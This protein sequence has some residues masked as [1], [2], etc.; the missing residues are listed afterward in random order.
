MIRLMTIAAMTTLV[1][2]ACKNKDYESKQLEDQE[3]STLYDEVMD[4]HDNVMPKMQDISKLRRELRKQIVEAKD[5]SI[6]M[7]DILYLNKADDAMMDWMARFSEEY[8][9]L[10]EK[11]QK[12][13]YLKNEIPAI[14]Y[15]R[16]IMLESIA[17]AQKRLDSL[18]N[19]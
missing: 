1:F 15:V 13:K 17:I 11:E 5:S 14:E 8:Q 10:Q 19:Q 12:L 9:L 18:T 7:K 4:I 3:V 16:D 2:I 6:I